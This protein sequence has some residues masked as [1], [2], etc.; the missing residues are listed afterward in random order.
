MGLIHPYIYRMAGT[1]AFQAQED[2]NNGTY[3]AEGPWN[4]CT[5]LGTPDGM[6]MLEEIERIIAEIT[7]EN[8]AKKAEEEANNIT[9]PENETSNA[10]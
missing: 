9:N 4:P 5:G 2:G 10:T 8:L 1:R 3:H 7:A 6:A